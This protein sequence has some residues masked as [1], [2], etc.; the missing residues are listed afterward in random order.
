MRKQGGSTQGGGR[1]GCIEAF[2]DTGDVMVS[3][4]DD[5]LLRA[6]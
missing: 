3:S 5:L 1:R 4:D 6:F 2:H